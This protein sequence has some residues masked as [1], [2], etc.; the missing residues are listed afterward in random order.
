ML[1]LAAVLLALLCTSV[2]AE[3]RATIATPAPTVEFVTT[4]GKPI[5]AATPP[6]LLEDTPYPDYPPA[7]AY[8]TFRVGFT[9][10]AL[11]VDAEGRVIRA[12]LRM[13]SGWAEYDAGFLRQASTWRFHPG[14]DKR[15]RPVVADVIQQMK[16]VERPEHAAARKAS[17]EAMTCAA[18]VAA[19]A[20]FAPP[21]IAE[22]LP[23]YTHLL[24]DEDTE[25]F[26]ELI[27][28]RSDALFTQVREAC[29]REPDARLQAV[30][31]RVKS[32][33]KVEYER[34]R[35]PRPPDA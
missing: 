22:Q 2:R 8:P 3:E 35:P 21:R 19:T 10:V 9:S 20:G 12:G 18:F 31:A 28:L 1:R 16:W 6:V 4:W 23:E 30:F 33:A 17:A 7:Q 29:A 15:G 25:D 26:P 5:E 27:W 34:T 24:M 13:K 32:A 14:R 11:R